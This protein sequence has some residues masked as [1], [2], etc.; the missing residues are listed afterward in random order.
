M[1]PQEIMEGIVSNSKRAQARRT[2]RAHMHKYRREMASRQR[3]GDI[4]GLERA[5]QRQREQQKIIEK[6]P[7]LKEAFDKS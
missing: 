6:F 7:E 2:E 3:W 1:L 4:A 5:K